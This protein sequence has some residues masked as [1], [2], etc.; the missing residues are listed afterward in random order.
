MF[1][2]TLPPYIYIYIHINII[3]IIYIYNIYIYILSYKVVSKLSRLRSEVWKSVEGVKGLDARVK[4]VK[5]VYGSS[6]VQVCYIYIYIYIYNYV[7]ICNYL[8]M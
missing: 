2:S 4:H 8:Y 1:L 5:D 6:D 3:Y 7:Y